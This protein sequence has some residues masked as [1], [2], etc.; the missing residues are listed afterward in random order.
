[1]LK[2]VSRIANTD[3]IVRAQTLSA[4]SEKF[5]RI[6]EMQSHSLLYRLIA[7]RVT[8]ST[9][10]YRGCRSGHT[11]SCGE[12]FELT[13]GPSV[14]LPIHANIPIFVRMGSSSTSKSW[15]SPHDPEGVDATEHPSKTIFST[16]LIHNKSL[17]LEL[18]VILDFTWN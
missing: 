7:K 18:S 10:H 12:V 3:F 1:M 11:L 15:K 6:F 8:C 16:R 5:E 17:L 13:F 9:K 14:V 2:H 4:F